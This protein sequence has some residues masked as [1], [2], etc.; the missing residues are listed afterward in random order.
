LL[1]EAFPSRVQAQ[2]PSA[3]SSSLQ[4]GEKFWIAHRQWLAK[5]EWE[6]SKE[7]LEKI[8][9]WK[10]DLGIR[11]HY[12]YSL[13]LLRESQQ[14]G[15]EGFP[16]AVPG[17]LEYAE[18]MAP[19]FSQ[20]P[21]ARAR[22]LWFQTTLSWENA[23]RALLDWFRGFSLSLVNLDEALPQWAN[24]GLW[25]LVSFLVIFGLFAFYL[26]VRY[27]SFF[28]HHMRHFLPLKI[29]FIPL[30]LLSLLLLLSPFFLGMAWMGLF[31]LWMVVFWTYA[32]RA[33][34]MVTVVLL[35]IMGLL[36]TGFRLYSSLLLAVS[37]NGVSEILRANTGV[38][39]PDLH[40]KLLVMVQNHP[41]DPDLLQAIGL[42]EKRMGKFDLAEQH[43]LLWTQVAPE[44]SAAFNN[45]GNIYLITNQVDR[46]MAAY[47]KSIQL[48]PA[49][50]EAYYNL[51]QAYLQ[52]LRLRDAEAEF[53]RARN[54]EPRLISYSTSIASRNPNRMAIDRTI[55]PIRV[56]KRVFSPVPEAERL[57]QGFWDLIW[58]GFPLQYGEAG[59]A[60]L[61]VLL[62]LIHLG[63]RR[64]PFIRNCE[65]CGKLICSRCSRSRVIGKQCVQC[66]NA[67]TANPS[68]DPVFAKKKRGEVARHQARM[69][70]FPPRISMILPGAGHLLLGKSPEGTLYMFFL[71]LF[72]TAAVLGTGQIPNPWVLTPSFSVPG[73]VLILFL[74]L[75]FYS[76]VQYRMRR[77]RA[78]G[79]NAYFRRT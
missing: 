16:G 74:F 59:V 34:R 3:L 72:L 37:G 52:K 5:R 71:V 42:V 40:Q 70:F 55:E 76:W 73:L 8:Y 6:K 41:Q 68:A 20:V 10:L 17:L 30:T 45:L 47:Q 14:M 12:S 75:F 44:S 66:L 50:A 60:V 27:F 2:S 63:A 24:L 9:Q 43:F 78:A 57:A 79:G 35:L 19:D 77:I 67:F 33:D 25:I 46:A 54:I 56:W 51:G 31:V 38:W 7:E 64:I 36:P 11:N 1:G 13:A 48:A 22:W 18:K 61:F 23:S 65:R 39:S 62:G 53:E 15:R 21:D 4:E 49:R 32:R 29:S 28:S 58:G 69:N 26:L